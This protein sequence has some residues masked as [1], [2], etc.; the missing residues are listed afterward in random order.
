[1]K[2][3]QS[4]FVK[5]LQDALKR[6]VEAV[7]E[8]LDQ[9]REAGNVLIERAHKLAVQLQ[10]LGEDVGQ[11]LRQAIQ[12][13]QG[14]VKDFVHKLLDRFRRPRLSTEAPL[15]RYKRSLGDHIPEVNEDEAVRKI[16][17]TVVRLALPM[18]RDRVRERCERHA[19]A[20][21]RRL[22]ERL[23]P[24]SHQPEVT[25]PEID[26]ELDRAEQ[27]DGEFISLRDRLSLPDRDTAITKFCDTIV[28]IVPQSRK[29][30]VRA[31]CVKRL[32]DAVNRAAEL[33]H[34]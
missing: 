11:K 23:H 8:K 17:D 15:P 30:Q 26:D 24:D 14:K 25:D 20:V 29:E 16:C 34:H 9:G 32:N 7:K 18:H 5:K 33:G 31:E 28:R 12:K 13:Y 1:L 4:E 19:R 22:N 10:K 6:T 2:Q 21:I 27:P 3:D